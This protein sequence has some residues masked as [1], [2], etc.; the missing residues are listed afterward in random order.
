MFEHILVP[1]DGSTLAE[2]VLSH[3]VAFASTFG[4]RV[5]LLHVLDRRQDNRGTTIVDPFT[6]HI[7]ETEA[8]SYLA[9]V[10]A[11]L[12]ASKVETTS[13]VVQGTPAERVI[14]YAGQQDVDLIVLSSHGA[15]GLSKWNVSSVV[16]KIMLRAYRSILLV[17]AYLPADGE[18][19][20]QSYRRLL[21]PVD[22][23]H[24]AEY[25]LPIAATLARRHGAELLLVHMVRRPEMPRRTLPT[26]EDIELSN[27]LVERNQQEMS[28]YLQELASSL[29]LDSDLRVLV[30]DDVPAAL[31][32]LIDGQRS[33]LVIMTAHGYSGASCWSY[34]SVAMNFVTNGST[35]L[36]IVQDLTRRDAELSQVELFVQEHQGH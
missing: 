26:K 4:S 23:S 19:Q 20:S 10:A 8:K 27:R 5:T 32:Q 35:P 7:A 34:G 9:E 33:D 31:H 14:A 24:R 13:V 28:A 11:R 30:G 15:S 18:A 16:Q 25:A 2:C 36:L 6:W 22:G 12:R 1:L 21:V 17:R 3:V 29:P